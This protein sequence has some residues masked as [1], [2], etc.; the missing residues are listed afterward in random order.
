MLGT[1]NIV[2]FQSSY[3][4]MRVDVEGS[5]D[6]DQVSEEEQVTR[7]VELHLDWMLDQAPK[8][9]LYRT[10]MW[11]F[12]QLQTIMA[13]NTREGSPPMIISTFWDLYLQNSTDSRANWS[14]QRLSIS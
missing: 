13:L 3:F 5:S 9:A 14:Q 10:T 4:L 2:E 6:G 11:S 12:Q 8:S 1:E 7:Y